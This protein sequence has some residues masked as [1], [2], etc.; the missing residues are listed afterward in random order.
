MTVW[1]GQTC[2]TQEPP[3]LAQTPARVGDLAAGA[4]KRSADARA[5]FRRA[6]KQY[7]SGRARQLFPMRSGTVAVHNIFNQFPYEDEP[8]FVE[9]AKE[10]LADEFYN[11]LESE[12]ALAAV[13]LDWLAP[14]VKERKA[15]APAGAE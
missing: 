10:E 9:N 14:L 5:A 2:R 4:D 8:N 12:L 3:G 6:V 11:D 7:K 1:S 15:A 13:Q